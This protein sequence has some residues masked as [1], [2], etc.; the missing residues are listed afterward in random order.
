MTKGRITK[1]RITKGR[2][3]KGR[4]R[5]GRITKGRITRGNVQNV[6]FSN[7]SEATIFSNFCWTKVDS[8][9]NVGLGWVKT[10]S[11]LSAACC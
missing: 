8:Y 9:K 1:G 6:K 10:I 3:T 2:M 7:F 4:I 5:K 11:R